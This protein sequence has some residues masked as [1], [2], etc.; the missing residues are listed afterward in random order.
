MLDQV[1]PAAAGSECDLYILSMHEKPGWK[2]RTPGDRLHAPHPGVGIRYQDELYELVAFGPAEGTPFVYRYSLRKWQDQYAVR[3]AFTYTLEAARET[4]RQL[5]E[6]RRQ[7]RQNSWV[8][9]WFAL[10]G[11]VPTALATRW[12]KEWGLPMRRSAF[13]SVF[14]LGITCMSAGPAWERAHGMGPVTMTF[15]YLQFEQAVRIIWLLSSNDAVGALWINTPWVLWTFVRGLNADGSPRRRTAKDFEIERDEVRHLTRGDEASSE[16]WDVE[17]H[18]VFRDPVLVGATPVR[19]EGQIYQPLACVQ[20]GEGIRRRYVFRLK[21]LDP[22]TPVKREYVR[23]RDAA[24]VAKLLPYERAR[25]AV[26]TFGFLCGFLPAERQIE[27]ERKYELNAGLWTQRSAWVMLFS[28]AV[29]IW[30]MW[31]IP[32]GVLVGIYFTLESA[33]RLFLSYS[34]GEPS[35]SALGFLLSPLLRF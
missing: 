29:Q 17:V 14:L 12:E 31:G 26:H 6:Q 33:G 13:V 24:L 3:Q 34:R 4:G 2:P 7:H 25:D 32:L 11:L 23:E 5:Q 35:G 27:L 10:T 22:Q 28:G 15:L 1:Q 19:V 20:E 21:K 18:S 16:P 30:L 8:V 9:V